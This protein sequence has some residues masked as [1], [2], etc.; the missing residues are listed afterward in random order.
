MK[1]RVYIGLLIIALVAFSSMAWAGDGLPRAGGYDITTAGS[2]PIVNVSGGS[3]EVKVPTPASQGVSNSRFKVARS[4]AW[5]DGNAWHLIAEEGDYTVPTTVVDK[6]YLKA[7]LGLPDIGNGWFWVR[8]WGVGS[9]SNPWLWINP[10]RFMRPD[11]NGKPGY[12]FLVNVKT[13]ETRPVPS[14]LETRQ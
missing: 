9:G 6:D 2:E 1:K 4:V 5:T 13:G 11:K 3:V 12:E 8:I 14:S 7:S 10:N